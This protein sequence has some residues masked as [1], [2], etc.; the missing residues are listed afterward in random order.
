MIATALH[1]RA[2]IRVDASPARDE[3]DCGSRLF[4]GDDDGARWALDP[5]GKAGDEAK[6]A[7]S[8][9]RSRR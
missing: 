1:W 3:L 8:E 2:G 4:A 5:P 7:R 6:G 9:E